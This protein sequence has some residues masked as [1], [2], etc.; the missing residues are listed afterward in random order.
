M[1]HDIGRT[2]IAMVR[3][4]ASTASTAHAAPSQTV[5]CSCSVAL[6]YVHVL[7]G[8]V[9]AHVHVHMHVH[10]YVDVCCCCCALLLPVS[11]SCVPVLSDRR[12]HVLDHATLARIHGTDVLRDTELDT[13]V[14]QQQQRDRIREKQ[15][16]K[17]GTNTKQQANG[18][19]K[20]KQN[21]HT[22]HQHKCLCALLWMCERAGELVVP[23]VPVSMCVPHVLLRMRFVVSVFRRCGYLCR[24]TAEQHAVWSV[25]FR[26]GD[27]N[28]T[29]RMRWLGLQQTTNTHDQGHRTQDTGHKTQD[30]GHNINRITKR[31]HT[32][33][34]DKTTPATRQ[35][36]M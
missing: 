22:G 3:R 9:Y 5:I 23:S 2:P 27:S 18:K 14:V 29:C 26:T 17:N 6:S 35:H 34:A 31:D 21:T 33:E 1:H 28:L 15:R 7:H 36:R 19:P 20:Q 16:N 32:T 11:V 30:T 8:H 4:T 24:R 25:W 10:G 12:D 13:Y